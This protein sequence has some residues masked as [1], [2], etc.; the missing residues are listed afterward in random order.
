MG[1]MEWDETMAIG[2]RE[3]DEQHKKL[4]SLI[5]EAYETIQR[6][7]EHR[8]PEIIDKMQDYAVI[9]FAT[10]EKIFRECNG[11]DV[12]EHKIQHKKFITD[13]EEFRQCQYGKTNLS[14][15]FVYLS[16]WLVT[17]IME[18]DMKWAELLPKEDVEK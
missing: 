13:V 8:M 4:L 12:D 6:H 5:N 14:Q 11:L 10:E 9:H 7:E 2:M 3:L 16:R 1:L 17:H 15:L 18:E